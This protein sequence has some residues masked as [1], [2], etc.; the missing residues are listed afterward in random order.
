MAK[1]PELLQEFERYTNLFWLALLLWLCVYF[2]GWVPAVPIY[3]VGLL[4]AIYY[5]H[6]VVS[7]VY[8]GEWE[9]QLVRLAE[10]SKEQPE[11]AKEAIKLSEEN[12]A[13]DAPEKAMRS[14][15]FVVAGVLWP[16]STV[17]CKI[18]LWM[19]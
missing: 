8:D 19:S 7:G 2:I 4:V 14:V 9:R 3:I 18:I 13:G 17:V 1:Q 5:I 12:P 11:L 15:M 6:A 10:A 16:I